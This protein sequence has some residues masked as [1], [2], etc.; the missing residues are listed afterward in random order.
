MGS[1]DQYV[2]GFYSWMKH[3]RSRQ[4]LNVFALYG[5][6]PQFRWSAVS[7]IPDEAALKRMVLEERENGAAVRIFQTS[8][9]RG[10]SRV[11]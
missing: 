4:V 11:I 1:L 6:T 2:Y 3:I 7:C 9:R 8:G 10:E 5:S